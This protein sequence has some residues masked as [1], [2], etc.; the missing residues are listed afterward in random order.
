MEVI[1]N[2]NKLPNKFYSILLLWQSARPGSS[3]KFSESSEFHIGTCRLGKV[4]VPPA[5][6]LSPSLGEGFVFIP[7]GACTCMWT[8]QI[9]CLRAIAPLQTATLATWLCMPECA[10][11][12]GGRGSEAVRARA[13][14]LGSWQ[15]TPHP[16]PHPFAQCITP[17]LLTS[18]CR[19][20]VKDARGLLGKKHLWK[21]KG[22]EVGLGRG[23]LRAARLISTLGRFLFQGKGPNWA[24]RASRC[25]VHLA[26]F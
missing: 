1:N 3:L 13:A 24:W 17:G 7:W 9:P 18:R 23:G 19:N 14:G 15:G 22:E 10:Q 2:A 20:G 6:C 4:A 26:K 8:P 12:L 21:I 16:H 25:G 11:P 5:G